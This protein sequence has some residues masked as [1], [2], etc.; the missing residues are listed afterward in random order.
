MINFNAFSIESSSTGVRL[1]IDTL[2][3][4]IK[5]VVAEKNQVE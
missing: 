1:L 2:I 4:E 3:D 5:F